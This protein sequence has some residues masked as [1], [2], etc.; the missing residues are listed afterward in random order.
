MSIGKKEVVILVVSSVL[1]GLCIGDGI[2]EA[3]LMYRAK[4]C[5]SRYLKKM[6][7]EFWD[8]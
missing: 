5:W 7:R 8:S 6:E 4:H 2:S 1:G 3:S